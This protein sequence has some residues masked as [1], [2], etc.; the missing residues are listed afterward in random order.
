MNYYTLLPTKYVKKQ[1]QYKNFDQYRI[2]IPNR[3]LICGSSGSGKTNVI[4]NLLLGMNC[5]TRVYLLAK[6]L[7]EPLYAFL[8]DEVR[9]VEAKLDR[10]ILVASN[11]LD[12]LPPVDSFDPS[13]NS[14]VIIDDMINEKSKKLDEVAAFWTRGRKQGVTSIFITQSYFAT[15]KKLRQST[16]VMIFKRLT[17]RDLT[18]VLADFSMDRTVDELMAMYKSCRTNQVDSFFMIDMSSQQDPKYMYRCGF[19]PI[20]E[21]ESDEE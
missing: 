8:I 2:S 1:K 5:W 7:E 6:N 11:T 3:I 16:D 13:E 18:S 14:V 15:P 12:D 17:K 10:Q 19:K 20:D 21:A 9:K 4:M